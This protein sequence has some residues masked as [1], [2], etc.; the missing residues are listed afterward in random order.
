[1]KCQIQIPDALKTA[2]ITL[3]HKRNSKFDLNNWR[4]VFV[5][6]VIRT[7]LMKL[8]HERTYTKVSS[9]MTDAQI[10]ARKHKSVRNHLFVLNSIISDVMSTKKKN[11]IDLNI[12][13]FKQMFDAEELPT[14]LNSFY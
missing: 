5:S 10:G 13:D 14:V 8:I 4:G 9:S 11:P 2:N 1:M 6:S 3:L 7:I 12:M